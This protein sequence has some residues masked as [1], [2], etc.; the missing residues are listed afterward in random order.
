[1][2]TE[3]YDWATKSNTYK[4]HAPGMVYASDS[5]CKTLA[6]AKEFIRHWLGV[7]RLPRNTQIYK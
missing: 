6:E 7:K 2:R 4:F 1:M 5:Y 3:Y